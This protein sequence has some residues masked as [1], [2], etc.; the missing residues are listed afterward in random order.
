LF[1]TIAAQLVTSSFVALMSVPSP[2]LKTAWPKSNI[3]PLDCPL[4]T[5]PHSIMIKVR[6]YIS[7]TE[8]SGVLRSGSC[9]SLNTIWFSCEFTLKTSEWLIEK[10]WSMYLARNWTQTMIQLGY[11]SLTSINWNWVIKSTPI[12]STSRIFNMP[13]WKSAFTSQ[14]SLLGRASFWVNTTGLWSDPIT[15]W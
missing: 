9:I 3:S 2:V 7:S 13:V 1:S 11:G 14:N 6:F 15:S 12:M 10:S 4:S 8:L 5:R